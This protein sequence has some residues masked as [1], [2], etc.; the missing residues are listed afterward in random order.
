M[1]QFTFPAY[2]DLIADAHGAKPVGLARRVE[3]DAG[4]AQETPRTHRNLVE[5]AVRYNVCSPADLTSFDVW[6]TA[7]RRGGGAFRW[8]DPIRVR[9]GKTGDARY[10]LARIKNGDVDV[11]VKGEAFKNYEL[12]FTLEYWSETTL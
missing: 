12:A 8:L 1:T 3:F 11:S 2:L 5:R 4:P 10:R 7:L 9:Q 6:W